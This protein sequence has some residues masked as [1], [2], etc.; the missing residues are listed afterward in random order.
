MVLE[1]TDN[2]MG[3][4]PEDQLEV[5]TKFFRTGQVKKA[6]I[7]GVGLGLVITK[8]IVEAHGGRITFESELGVGTT[9]RVELPVESGR[10]DVAAAR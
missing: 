6:A 5:F 1:V 2:G 8:S 9:F 4:S 10:M 7:P 3:M